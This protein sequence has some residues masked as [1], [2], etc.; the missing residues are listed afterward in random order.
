MLLMERESEIENSDHDLLERYNTE[1]LISE[2]GGLGFDLDQNTEKVLHEMIRKGYINVDGDGRFSPEKPAKSMVQLLDQ[3][4]PGMPGMNF[5]AYL[6]Q[7]IDEINSERKDLNS[8]VSQLDQMLH[9]QGVP[10]KKEQ[11]QQEASAQQ[12]GQ[13]GKIQTP[14]EREGKRSD[15]FGRK[16]F[17][18]YSNGTGMS[19]SESRILSYAELKDKFEVREVRFGSSFSKKEEPKEVVSEP[20][21]ELS[22]EQKV[23]GSIYGIS[24]ESFLQMAQ[25]EKTTCTLTVKTDDEIGYIYLL[26]G[27]LMS[28]ETESL[29]NNA[30]FYRIIGWENAAIEI[31]NECSKTVNEINQPLI[32]LLMEG[33]KIKDEK[34]T[35]EYPASSTENLTEDHPTQLLEEMEDAVLQIDDNDEL[36]GPEQKNDP[37]ISSET[38]VFDTTDDDIEKRVTAFEEDLS[39]E[40]PICRR[41]KI[42]NEETKM[43]KSYYR[44]SS[45]T[46]S[47]ISWGKPYHLPCP[48]CHN[49]FLVETSG[50]DG[51]PIL[52]CPRATCRHR[53]GL[54]GKEIDND[55][56][57]ND[58][59]DKGKK[60]V[61]STSLKPRRKVVKRR[62]VR[63][64]K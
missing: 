15:I 26:E 23:G 6:V 49:P 57:E 41:S 27:E 64:K 54:P 35:K 62:R 38:D 59:P 44:C 31:E 16:K 3:A 30:A 29:K 48:T 37:D 22:F 21:P 46:C 5:V 28:A 52:K 47:F 20:P 2:L 25:L 42:K 51:K 55:Q 53:Q 36:E 40:C 17:E 18:K 39:L 45:K 43:G 12:S 13:K 50:R 32:N 58:S 8:A 4:F 34:T 1:T 60:K 24:L 9:M 14:Q 56:T 63:R 10:L 33:L 7:T 11:L 61:A 19:S